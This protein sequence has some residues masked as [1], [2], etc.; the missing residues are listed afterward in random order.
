MVTI[1]ELRKMTAKDLEM[2]LVK[3]RYKIGSTKFALKAGHKQASHEL[4]DASKYVAR[5][6]TLLKSVREKEMAES[7]VKESK[8]S[9]EEVN[10]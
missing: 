5:I 10:K 8:V 3:T 1:K 6:L 7:L 9:K 2:E 4:K